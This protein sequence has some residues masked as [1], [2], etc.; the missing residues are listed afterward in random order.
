MTAEFNSDDP[1]TRSIDAAAC[2]TGY[3]GQVH[4]GNLPAGRI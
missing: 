4:C 3:G 2:L 1:V